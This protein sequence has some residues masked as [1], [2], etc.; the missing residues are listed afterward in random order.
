MSTTPKTIETIFK[1]NYL[2]IESETTLIY[3]LER[4]IKHNE[5]DDLDV[6]E[7]V[8]PAL[9]HIRFLTLTPKEIS[10]TSLLTA[11]EIK[12]V[13]ETL[14]DDELSKMPSYLSVNKMIREKK[15][16][17]RSSSFKFAG[18]PQTPI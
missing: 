11:D 2:D 1:A 8:R 13:I 16:F 6:K 5:E 12:L 15:T 7:K 14:T 10:R 17:N 18:T 3:A 9:N 4:Y